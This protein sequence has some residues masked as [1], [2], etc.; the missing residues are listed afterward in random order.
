MLAPAESKDIHPLG[1]FPIVVIE[2]DNPAAAS[3]PSADKR[4]KVVLAESG[5]ITEYLC[6][7]YDGVGKGLVP[8]RYVPGMEGK[9]AG[10]SETWMR[11]RFFMHY[12]EGS[13]MANLVTGLVVRCKSDKLYHPLNQPANQVVYLASSNP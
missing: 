10:E 5:S 12:V 1:K 9:L 11:Y 7:Y 3:D 2:T 4:K 13:L 8:A 6:D